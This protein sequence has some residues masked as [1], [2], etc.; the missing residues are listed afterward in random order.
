MDSKTSI[1]PWLTV[2]NGKHALEFYQNAFNAKV[3]Y[4]LDTPDDSVVARLS[5][6]GSEFWISDGEGNSPLGGDSIR[7]ILSVDDPDK[8]FS[9]ALQAGAKQIFPVA[10]QHGWRSGR[11][12][13]PFG[14]HWEISRELKAN[15]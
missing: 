4:K 15:R 9:Q 8:V 5:I 1:A 6:D 2:H 14:L 7:M 10:E 11:L 13:D 12:V 3:V